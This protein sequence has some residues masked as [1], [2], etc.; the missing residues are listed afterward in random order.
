MNMKS[1]EDTGKNKPILSIC[2]PTFNRDSFLRQC[3]E[4][5]VRQFDNEQVRANVEIVISDNGSS[6]NTGLVAREYQKNYPN[7][8]YIRNLENLGV[9]R[10]ILQVVDMARGEYVWLLGD[11]DALFEDSLP[12]MLPILQTR[13]FFYLLANCWGFNREM[14]QKAVSR[15]NMTL[16]E[17][18]EYKTLADFVRTIKNHKD[19][20]G[21][22]GGLS[23]QLF[24]REQWQRFSGKEKYIGT[25]AIHLHII[26]SAFRD[27][28]I[29]VLAK[30]L[31]KTRADN[32]RWDTFPGLETASKRALA[33]RDG[34]KWI[35]DLYKIPYS[36]ISLNIAC[37]TGMAYSVIFN[38]ARKTIFSNPATRNFIK[39]ILGK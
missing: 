26:L 19:I 32:M 3:L 37:Y 9:D 22:F 36:N 4:S 6:D 20:V 21:Y 18:Q 35:Y 38:L 17:N 7:I 14:T 24:L 2:I 5:I 34:Q 27:L 15:P 30:P 13:K 33:T 1:E 29:A 28:P 8:A 23:V 16:S 31:V 25:Q 12:Y 11:D 10:N 39:R